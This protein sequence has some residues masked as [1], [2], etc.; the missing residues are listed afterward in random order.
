MI[1]LCA[2]IGPVGNDPY[3]ACKMQELGL[4]GDYEWSEEKIEEFKAV[5][6]KYEKGGE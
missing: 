1:K 4:K 2:C 3:C 6:E 5:L